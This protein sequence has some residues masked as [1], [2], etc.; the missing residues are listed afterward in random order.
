MNKKQ[1]KRIQNQLRIISSQVLRNEVLKRAER[2]LVP[3]VAKQGQIQELIHFR[4]NECGLWYRPFDL[5]VDHIDE[6]GEF[7]IKVLKNKGHD[8]G[9]VRVDW[10]DYIERMFCDLCNLQLLCVSCHQSK[11]TKFN[12][13]LRRARI[14]EGNN[15]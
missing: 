4:C 6:V 10:G 7:K 5:E 15:F 14:D 2:K 13:S 3:G 12:M 9:E 11:T 8:Y 1:A